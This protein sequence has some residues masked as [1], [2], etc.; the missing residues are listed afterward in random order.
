MVAA[1]YDSESDFLLYKTKFTP[2]LGDLL[3]QMLTT[4]SIQFSDSTKNIPSSSA[5]FIPSELSFGNLHGLS[6][7][8]HK[9]L[10]LREYVDMIQTDD[11][12][13]GVK[14]LLYKLKELY[15]I[16]KIKP[17]KGKY[18]K[19][20]AAPKKRYLIG[21]REIMKNLMAGKIKMLILAVDVERVEGAQGLDEYLQ[22]M[23]Q[24]C[25]RQGVPVVSCMSRS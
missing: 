20:N 9:R 19:V 11:L 6:K 17:Q 13:E 8:D 16:R 5:V 10:K 22:V 25:S 4:E 15:F 14:A 1:G 23:L 21:L 2:I 12:K 3:D 18:K 24:Q 7:K